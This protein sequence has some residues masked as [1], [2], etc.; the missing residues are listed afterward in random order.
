MLDI[1]L[2]AISMALVVAAFVCGCVLGHKAG[3]ASH[4][5]TYCGEEGKSEEQLEAEKRDREFLINQQKAFHKVQSYSMETA[6]GL[7]DEGGGI[8]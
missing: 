6:Y 5:A 3:A 7:D 2:G 4:M 8:L 1:L